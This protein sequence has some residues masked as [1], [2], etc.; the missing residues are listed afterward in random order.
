MMIN[1]Y[2]GKCHKCAATVAEGAG[3]AVRNAAGK[4]AT[5]CNRSGCLG[6]NTA[7]AVAATAATIDDNGRIV[8]PYNADHVAQIKG[9]RGARWD[10]AGKAWTVAVE[11][12]DLPAVGALARAIGLAVAPAL[13]TRIADVAAAPVIESTAEARARAA[14]ARDYQIEGVRFLTARRGAILADE[15]GTGK[16]AQ[17]LWALPE[18][19]GAV[20]V[21]PAGLLYNWRAEARRWRP[22][23][24][25]TIA[26]R[27]TFQWPCA[28]ALV[29]LS[30]EAT[31]LSWASPTAD[32]EAAA[33]QTS[34][35]L[36]EA[37]WSKNRKAARTQRIQEIAKAAASVWAVTGTP[38]LN[39][40]FDL[41]T[42]LSTVNGTR[43]V[44]GGWRGFTAAFGGAQDAWGGWT[45]RAPGPEV[46]VKLRRIM[47]RRTKAEVLPHLPAKTRRE[48]E[49]DPGA[50][51][52]ELDAAHEESLSALIR[53][54]RG[55]VHDRDA[56][57][58]AT[59]RILAAGVP[60]AMAYLSQNNIH[61]SE[62]AA[63]V[64]L[65]A[66][67][68]ERATAFERISEIRAMLATAKIP[69]M[70]E[71]VES[72]E[73]AGTPLVVASAHRAPVDALAMRP[74]WAV[75]T[76][77]VSPQERQEIVTEFQAGRLYGVALTIAAGGVGLT[78]TKAAD[79]LF[80]DRD[81][82][83][84]LNLQAEDR[85][86]R[87]GQDRPVTYSYL[88]I[89]HP[90]ERRIAALLGVKSALAAAT[91]DA[92]PPTPTEATTPAVV[93]PTVIIETE[94][95]AAA[96]LAEVDARITA[97]TPVHARRAA[98]IADTRTRIV[99]WR[100]RYVTEDIAGEISAEI[101]CKVEAAAAYLHSVCD[102]AQAKDGAGFNK[103]DA[104]I[105]GRLLELEHGPDRTRILLALCRKYTKTQLAGW[106]L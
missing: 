75:I 39:T 76:G 34:L 87:I 15:M 83:P 57:S 55:L 29:L 21:A 94:E 25:V 99:V 85:I 65:G 26:T 18:T 9:L 68:V 77:D 67:Q 100:D 12:R 80:V 64:L 41:W 91:L 36:D 90:I 17:I 53:R 13:A 96:R 52:V 47:I 69:V 24:R 97:T 56:R 4:W 66:E 104:A 3:F 59:A 23:L 19:R 106:G 103:P 63:A 105:A 88:T 79:M 84:A 16:T 1:K 74:G 98:R 38:L 42:L 43:D 44:F 58:H 93:R 82:T 71:M 28:G 73:A 37:H 62:E 54:L 60:E 40:P 89:D 86:H 49:I 35:V 81:W 20:V 5:V 92:A 10:G 48:V 2:A 14:G 70:L 6:S 101:A 61:M 78:L 45:F 102:G 7:A 8:A 72:Y 30:P 51:A 50:A 31:P 22:D 11:D 46:A 32:E 33:A 95:E 27:E